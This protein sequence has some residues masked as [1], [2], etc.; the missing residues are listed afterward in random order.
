MKIDVNALTEELE[1]TKELKSF[2]NAEIEATQQPEVD[3]ENVSDFVIKKTSLVI[4]Q[5]VNALEE[6]KNTVFRG[7]TPE[8]IE[9]YAKL[10]TSV[11]TALDVLNKFNIAKEKN[12]TA[13]E[14]KQ[15][16]PSGP[17]NQTNNILVTGTREDVM[18]MLFGDEKDKAEKND[19]I[20]A[21]VE[22]KE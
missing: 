8:E 20:E 21:E 9:S 16:G 1:K 12:D 14:L 18:K 2:V 13:K 22:E 6:I 5:G 3:R 17:T 15:S 10:F 19:A 11:T 4:T 7:G